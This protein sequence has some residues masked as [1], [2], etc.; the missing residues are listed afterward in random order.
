MLRKFQ[1]LGSALLLSGGCSISD[2]VASYLDAL[3]YAKDAHWECKNPGSTES[4]PSRPDITLCLERMAAQDPNIEMHMSC[5]TPA[6]RA[7]GTCLQESSCSDG[8]I[9]SCFNEMEFAYQ[10]CARNFPARWYSCYEE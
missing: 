6:E 10:D 4:A 1:A 9:R 3:D 5:M 7:L 2:T 8:E